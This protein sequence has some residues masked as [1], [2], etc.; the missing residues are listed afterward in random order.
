MKLKYF[1]LLS[2]IVNE[3]SLIY[4][5][6]IVCNKNK[7]SLDIFFFKIE[8]KANCFHSVKGINCNKQTCADSRPFCNLGKS[9]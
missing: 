6:V 5:F 3:V 7:S 2:V 1:F 4:F 8:F 9:V